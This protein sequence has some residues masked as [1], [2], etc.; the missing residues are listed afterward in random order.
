MLKHTLCH[1]PGLGPK[2]ERDLWH[3]GIMSWDDILGGAKIGCKRCSLRS[4]KRSIEESVVQLEHHNPA[5]FYKGLPPGERWRIFADFRDCT[6]YLD[7]ETNGL[8]GSLSHITT[9][10]VY[11]GK[12][13]RHYVYG[14]NLD[15][16]RED[17]RPY[18]VIV[19]Y[20]GK[21]FDIPVIEQHFGIEM[22]QAHIDLRFL[23]HSLGYKGGLKGCEKMLGLDREDLNGV[24]GFF[25]VLLWNDYLERGD[26]RSLETL[27]AYNV[28][29]AVNLER[30]MVV[31]YNLK[32]KDTPFYL[33]DRLE[34]P[35]EVANPFKPDLGTVK[36]IKDEVQW[37]RFS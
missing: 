30:L 22:P 12:E 16:F 33:D 15:D 10:A 13:V 1:V 3:K 5:Y 32:I 36:R 26:R 21:C 27:L 4:V 24:D 23:L 20:N 34:I 25:A 37:Y 35:P 31:A 18:Q 28:L 17:I 6:A 9:I 11:D 14:E 2:T 19:T 8:N 7:I 29:D